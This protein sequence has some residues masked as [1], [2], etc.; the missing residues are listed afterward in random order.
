[1][2]KITLIIFS[3]L[4]FSCGKTTTSKTENNDY[5]PL[6]TIDEWINN[7]ES[8]QQ[9]YQQGEVVKV[10]KDDNQGSPHQKFLAKLDNGKTLLISHNTELAERIPN[11]KKGDRVS[12]YGEYEWNSKGGVVHWT[13]HDPKGRHLDGYLLHNGT[14]YN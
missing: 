12:F 3:F 14:K 5:T 8:N 10:L 1:M 4:I 2:K 7:H 9:I 13:H 11:L 6:S